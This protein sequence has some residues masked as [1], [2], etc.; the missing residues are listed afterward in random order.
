[1]DGKNRENNGPSY[2]QCNTVIEPEGYVRLWVFIILYVITFG[3]YM[4]FWVY[5]TVGLFNKKTGSTDGQVQQLLLCAFVPFYTLYWLYK[6]TN[7]FSK[8]SASVG[9]VAKSSLTTTCMILALSPWITTLVGFVL[10]YSPIGWLF[11]IVG[12]VCSI[13]AY[14]T[15]QN[16]INNCLL[17]ELNDG[18]GSIACVNDIE[19]PRASAV[20]TERICEKSKNQQDA[21]NIT[22][23]QPIYDTS[24]LTKSARYVTTRN[25]DVDVVKQLRELKTLYD[26]GIL[27]EEEFDY[28]KRELLK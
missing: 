19:K 4:W 14:A 27:T 2:L 24:E 17:C 25:P 28:K 3:I 1:M 13:A 20:K 23:K 18:R 12:Y 9:Y 7:L 8:Y 26:E 10:F 16:A 21:A 15:F 5:K 11:T 22:A 6:Y